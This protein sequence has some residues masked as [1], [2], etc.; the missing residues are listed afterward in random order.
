MTDPHDESP[1]LINTPLKVINI[2]LEAFADDLKENGVEVVHLDWAPPA[3]GN[4][5]L[6]E[7][8]VKLGV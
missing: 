2:G 6:A 7:L 5:R 3:A 1:P 4:P 8:L